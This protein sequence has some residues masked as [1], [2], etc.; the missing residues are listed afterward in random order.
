MALES[1]C[2]N[3]YAAQ[4]FVDV[5]VVTIV[6]TASGRDANRSCPNTTVGAFAGTG[7]IVCTMPSGQFQVSIGQE[8]VNS[9]TDKIAITALSSANGVTTFTAT[10]S[11]GADPAGSEEIHLTFL[12]FG[13]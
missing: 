13:S 4:Q 3:L 10:K 5:N 8:C 12:V 1:T 9:G 7:A 2:R 11:D 6:I